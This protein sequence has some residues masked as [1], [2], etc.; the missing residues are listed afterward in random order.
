MRMRRLRQVVLQ[1]VATATLAGAVP[2]AAGAQTLSYNGEF[3]GV[4][5]VNS[6]RGTALGNAMM[7]DNLV[8]SGSFAAITGFFGEFLTNTTW[9]TADYEI[10]TGVS[11]GNAGTLL[12]SGTGVSATQ[13]ATGRSAFGLTEYRV[14]IAEGLL[15]APGTYWLGIAPVASGSVFIDLSTTSGA[16]GVNAT[17]DKVSFY[18]AT[19]TNYVTDFFGDYDFSYGFEGT[20]LNPAACDPGD[21]D[22]GGDGDVVPEPA[23]MTLLAT[24]LAGMA[25][26]RRRRKTRST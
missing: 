12:F 20:C 4:N 13:T 16:N 24:G 18:R 5:A 26:S 1:V 9:T 11:A 3:D 19:A 17:L 7:F 21:G 25:A 15:L 8:I 22:G 10:R 14:S 2:M 23:T 6:S